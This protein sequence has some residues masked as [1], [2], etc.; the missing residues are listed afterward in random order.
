MEKNQRKLNFETIFSYTEYD[1]LLRACFFRNKTSNMRDLSQNLFH[2]F[3]FVIWSL[4]III[5]LQSQ[6]VFSSLNVRVVE[7]SPSTCYG[8]SDG[9]AEIIIDGDYPPLSVRWDTQPKSNSLRM[10]GLAAGKHF[11][12]LKDRSGNTFIDSVVVGSQ[13][14]IQVQTL[15]IS[16]ESLPGAKDGTAKIEVLE[17]EGDLTFFWEG[18]PNEKG[19][20]LS[21]IGAG[22]Y[23]V[24]ARDERG[25]ETTEAVTLVQMESAE[26]DYTGLFDLIQGFAPS[27]EFSLSPNPSSGKVQLILSEELKRE[28]ASIKVFDISG[29][30][31]Y[32]SQHIYGGE[33]QLDFSHMRTGL[34][35]VVLEYRAGQVTKKL[36][37]N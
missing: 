37:L 34:Y 29:R 27:E 31:V 32:A 15:V 8:V 1:S 28:P 5:P 19:A 35:S 26:P 25:C 13:S 3:I 21:G 16:D 36:L 10:E 17:S 7:V 20:V 11:V 6:P 9:I 30:Q 14:S 23:T 24:T 2:S 4:L 22:M 12:Y 18:Y 33:A